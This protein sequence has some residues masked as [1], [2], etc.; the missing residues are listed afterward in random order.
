MRLRRDVSNA[1]NEATTEC[2]LAIVRNEANVNPVRNSAA[3]RESGNATIAKSDDQA[4]YSGG[5]GC[6]VSVKQ[7]FDP[8]HKVR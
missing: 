1:P 7:L 8:F 4:D 6:S 5:S 3:R 2:D